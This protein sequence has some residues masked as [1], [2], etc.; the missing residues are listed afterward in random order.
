M[1]GIRGAPQTEAEQQLKRDANG[2]CCVKD[3]CLRFNIYDRVA[4]LFCASQ[5]TAAFGIPIITSLY[6]SSEYLGVYIVPLL[7]YHPMQLVIDSFLVQPLSQRV[8]KYEKAMDIV[9]GDDDNEEEEE[10]EVEPKEEELGLNTWQEQENTLK[11]DDDEGLFSGDEVN[12]SVID[13]D[14]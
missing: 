2:S 11:T 10:E 14:Q 8:A 12:V 1:S 3:D 6:E 9:N 13:Y 5:K 4:I 7:I